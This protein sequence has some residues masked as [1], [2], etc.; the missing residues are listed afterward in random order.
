MCG[1]ALAADPARPNF[2]GTWKLNTN[3]ST[4]DGPPDRVYIVTV[5]QAKNSVTSSTKAEGV[6]NLLD[7]TFPI[8]EK[9]RIEKQGNN[10]RYSKA[11]FEGGT[12]VFEVTDR[13]SK[14]D[15]AKTIF[16]VRESWQLSP[17]GK[18]LTKFRQTAAPSTVPG[19]RPTR[20]DQKYVFDKQ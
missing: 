15:T 3:K 11:Y 10:Y 16:Y 20:T 5:S 14:K 17:D 6:T 18:V 1:A 19:E 8:S 9:F 7:G 2:S 4:Q 13:D 12:L